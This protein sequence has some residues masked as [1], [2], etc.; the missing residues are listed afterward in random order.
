[1]R[2]VLVIL[3]SDITDAVAAAT[4]VSFSVPTSLNKHFLVGRSVKSFYTGREN[5]MA[6]L[7]AAFEQR[8]PGQKIFVIYG[9]GWD[10]KS[11]MLGLCSWLGI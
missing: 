4:A 9:L 3:L 11:I 8:Y 10:G 6:I 2:Y 1:M 7:N 5:Q